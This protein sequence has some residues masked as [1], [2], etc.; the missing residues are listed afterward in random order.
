MCIHDG[1]PKVCKAKGMEHCVS[2][3]FL[4]SIS[5]RL[6]DVEDGPQIGL[7]CRCCNHKHAMQPLIMASPIECVFDAAGS[8]YYGGHNNWSPI[9]GL[10]ANAITQW[11]KGDYPNANNQVCLREASLL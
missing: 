11:S 7:L 2:L 10:G 9:M 8:T 1:I 3:V 5:A 6:A 4:Q